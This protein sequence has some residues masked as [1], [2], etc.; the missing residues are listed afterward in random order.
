MAHVIYYMGAVMPHITG[1][2]AGRS[3]DGVRAYVHTC[4]RA[5]HGLTML[6]YVLIELLQCAVRRGILVERLML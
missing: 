2:A 5:Y 1:H 3:N 6:M 4:I